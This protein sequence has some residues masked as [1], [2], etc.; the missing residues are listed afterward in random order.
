MDDVIRQKAYALLESPLASPGRTIF[1]YHIEQILLTLAESE[2]G[3]E[4]TSDLAVGRWL[5][6]TFQAVLQDSVDAT[7]PI[8]SQ[9]K[10]LAYLLGMGPYAFHKIPLA[11]RELLRTLPVLRAGQ[12]LRV[13][14]VGASPGVGSLSLLYFF[15]LYANALDM[16]DVM[17]DESRVQVE[18]TPWDASKEALD[19]YS[20][21]I[22]NYVPSLSNFSYEVNGSIA[23]SIGPDTKFADHL[24]ES[25]FD[26]IILNQL[27]SEMRDIG[28][29]RRAQ[30]V[31][32]LSAH[33][34]D[35]G[36]LVVVESSAPG[37]IQATNQ[38]KSRIVT[39]GL[40]LYGPCTHLF[41]EPSGSICFTCTLSRR[42]ESPISR[43]SQLF[44]GVVGQT[45]L[46]D[47]ISKN[48]WTYG[49]FRKDGNIH[50]EPQTMEGAVRIADIAR[51]KSS[52]R[53]RFYVQ[54]AKKELEPFPYYKVC[55]QTAKT[56]ECYM[57]FESGI[58]VPDWEI[59]ALIHLENVRFE[60]DKRP[61][62]EKF[63]NSFYLIVD[64]NTAV[65]DLTAVGRKVHIPEI[66]NAGV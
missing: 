17:G 56:D 29:E 2:L 63:K 4:W 64:A 8:W 66:W 39:K 59:G 15:E 19:L 55:D 60:H 33:L 30:L 26:L 62:G 7:S 12:P 43:L 21:L 31:V 47:L 44:F 38:I 9:E 57:V 48:M 46:N 24:G 18:L 34:M 3:P 40:G 1:P 35:N 13:L 5:K 61:G 32:D 28:L 36:A 37:N 6:P 23:A 25:Q 10:Y 52:G 65:N 41:G 45:A 11:L 58:T 42:E 22:Y 49:V 50:H 51:D 14:D 53:G 16:L 54:I 27:L 20:K